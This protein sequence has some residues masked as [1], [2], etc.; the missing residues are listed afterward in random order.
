MAPNTIEK[1]WVSNFPVR[2]VKRLDSSTINKIALE[3]Q[4][5]DLKKS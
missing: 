4:N 2:K 3:L 1:S 5:G